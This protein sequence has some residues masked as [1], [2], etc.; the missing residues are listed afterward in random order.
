MSNNIPSEL[1]STP[2]FTGVSGTSKPQ[3]NQTKGIT[4]NNDYEKIKQSFFDKLKA[5][6]NPRQHSNRQGLIGDKIEIEGTADYFKIHIICMFFLM[7]KVQ[8]RNLFRI[9]SRYPNL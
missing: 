7:H 3:S 2:K 8:F 4:N 5:P 6:F 9:Y 1:P